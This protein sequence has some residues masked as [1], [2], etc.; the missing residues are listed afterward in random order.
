[1][2]EEFATPQKSGNLFR[3]FLKMKFSVYQTTGKTRKSINQLFSYEGPAWSLER[4]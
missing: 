4:A 2:H 3:F 1:M